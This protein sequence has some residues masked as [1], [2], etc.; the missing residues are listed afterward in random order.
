MFTL[1]RTDIL[2]LSQKQGCG[3]DFNTKFDFNTESILALS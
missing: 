1:V 2:T 3:V